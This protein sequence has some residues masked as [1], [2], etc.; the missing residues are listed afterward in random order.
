[1]LFNMSEL[2]I[3]LHQHLY[4]VDPPDTTS[5]SKIEASAA[6]EVFRFTDLSAELQKTVLEKYFEDLTFSL[7]ETIEVVGNNT[8][9]NGKVTS[10]ENILTLLLVS[11]DF[12]HEVLK[13]L[14]K[15]GNGTYEMSIPF[16]FI[17]SSKLNS[18]FL[19]FGRRIDCG[20]TTVVA[21]G[22]EKV[23]VPFRTRFKNLQHIKIK[24]PIDFNIT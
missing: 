17:S 19:A 10:R 1:M 7:E 6:A 3:L 23:T 20:I 2:S 9:L 4:L 13:A 24:E 22:R 18:S 15:S 14:G 21:G 12:Q 8:H 5:T 16:A 11:H